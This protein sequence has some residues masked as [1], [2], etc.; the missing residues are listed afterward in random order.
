M[1]AESSVEERAK[2]RRGEVFFFSSVCHFFHFFPWGLFFFLLASTDPLGAPIRELYV[3]Y[4]E[5]ILDYLISVLTR[6]Y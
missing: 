3:L 1:V 5:Y 4:E 6:V 2:K